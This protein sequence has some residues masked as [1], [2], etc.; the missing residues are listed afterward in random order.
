MAHNYK[1]LATDGHIGSS[2]TLVPQLDKLMRIGT[3]TISLWSPL[4]IVLIITNSLSF[5]ALIRFYW[6]SSSNNPM[7]LSG[8][9]AQAHLLNTISKPFYWTTAY[10]TVENETIADNLWDRILPSHGFVAIDRT[11]AK[12]HNWPESMYLP[13]DQSKGVYLLEA[14]HYLHCL[15]ILRKTLLEAADQKPYTYQPGAHT[16]HCFDALRQYVICNADSTPLYTFG[17]FT[18]GDGQVHQCKD[19]SQLREYATEHTACYKDSIEGIP[20]GDHFGFC[21]D[22]DDGVLG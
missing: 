3:N 16:N 22:G 15:K 18:A 1:P 9:A 8:N 12:E 2:A 11:Q 13:S 7:N 20:L 19:W 4:T 21:D 14:Y 5:L 17:D 6:T 10:S